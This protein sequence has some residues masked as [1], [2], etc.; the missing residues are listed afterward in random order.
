MNISREERIRGGLWGSLAGD[1]LGVP[2]EFMGRASLRENPVTGMREFGTHRQP[3]G[4]WSDDGALLLCSAESLVMG[5]F[6]TADMG[7]RFLR[8]MDKGLWTATGEVFDIGNATSN[9][10]SRI[11]MGTPAG[12]AGGCD[13]LSNGNGSLMRIL[14]V[15]LRFAAAPQAQLI[16]RAE[17]ASA[18]THGHQRSRMACALHALVTA[19]LLDGAAPRAAVE[20]ARADFTSVYAKSPEFPRFRALMEDDFVSLAADEIR[21]TGY[22]LDTL[23]ASLW[24]LLTSDSSRGCMLKA[25]NLGG[26]SDTTCCVAGG[27]AGVVFGEESLPEEWINALPR[28]AELK[29]LFASFVITCRNAG[30][31]N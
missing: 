30:I 26:D 4:T 17:R 3:A 24:C 13:E 25:V 5:E 23:H 19:R 31:S 2:V 1:A 7:S 21:S 14:P 11:A 22:V 28:H 9:A 27:L 6:D 16:D 12:E 8:W 29:N 10:L 15:S 20:A 18:I